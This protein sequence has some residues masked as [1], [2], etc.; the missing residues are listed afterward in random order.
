MRSEQE[1]VV[2]EDEWLAGLLNALLPGGD[3]FPAARDTGMLEVLASRLRQADA[4]TLPR[5][6]ESLYTRG[7]PPVDDAAWHEAARRLEALEPKLFGTIRKYAY[8]TYYEQ[9][10]V[11]DA[12]H[13]LGLQYNH[14]PLPAGYPADPFLV[15]RDAPRQPHGRWLRTEDVLP[16]DVSV[17]G[18]EPVR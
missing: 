2:T 1:G 14:S 8:L 7:A 6:A 10:T 5:L 17:L 4:S 18:L 12:I 11:V 15:E 9:P 13:A 16:V 3:G